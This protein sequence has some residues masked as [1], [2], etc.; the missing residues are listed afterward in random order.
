MENLRKILK[1]FQVTINFR[2]EEES[3]KLLPAHR[4]YI[5]QLIEKNIIEYY[6]V[7]LE[8]KRAWIIINATDKTEVEDHLSKSPFFKYWEFEIDELFL[9]DG[10]TYRLPALQL[11]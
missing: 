1:R 11:N 10:Q 9:F 5:N 8:T 4:D 7:S 6:T 2:M 3:F